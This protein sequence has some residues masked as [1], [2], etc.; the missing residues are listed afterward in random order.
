MY[1]S[2]FWRTESPK[3]KYWSTQFLVKALFLA[4]T[5]VFIGT[6]LSLVCIERERISKL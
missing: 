4:C 2:W 5:C 3:P 6:F 1:F